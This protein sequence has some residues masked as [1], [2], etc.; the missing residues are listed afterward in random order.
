MSNQKKKIFINKRLLVL[1]Y[2]FILLILIS[3]VILQQ[4]K[5]N[6]LDYKIK[7][8]FIYINEINDFG[9]TYAHE[10]GRIY[11]QNKLKN[12]DTIYKEN[13]SPDNLL[14]II[15]ELIEKEKCKIIVTTSYSYYPI[16]LNIVD[17]YPD[18][19]FLSCAGLQPK[20]NLIPYMVDLYQIYYLNGLI[21]AA[22][23]KND[24]LGYIGAYKIPELIRH[25]NA[26]TL[27][28]KE[29][30]PDVRLSL[31]WLNSW[32]N[33][34]KTSKIAQKMLDSRI[35]VI[36]YT[37]DSSSV[38]QTLQKYYEN[39]GKKVYTFSHY[40]PM[41]K[42]GQ[43]VV[44]SGQIVDWGLIYVDLF[45]RIANGIL[46]SKIYYW[47]ADSNAAIL[48]KNYS[49]MLKEEV[50]A[51]LKK[52]KIDVGFELMDLYNYILYRYNQVKDPLTSF[53]PFTG[54]I[55]SKNNILRIPDRQR[56]NLYDL[57]TM[58]WLLPNINEVTY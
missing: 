35:E 5:I 20:K 47:F 23:S 2:F 19:I 56:I 26:F 11:L 44:V 58:D 27:G 54:P 10:A 53:D 25:I 52:K 32:Y 13:V 8:G 17:K 49:T 40:S 21:A 34:E 55:Y 6:R 3:I 31:Y 24:E 15:D 36:A 45:T 28:A 7:A 1:A 18:I 37:E 51:E 33:P 42:F 9:W 50:I 57:L 30:N 4:I 22:L 48:G 39:T 14:N 46:D 29:I 38:A 16:L 41:D 43:D 12:I